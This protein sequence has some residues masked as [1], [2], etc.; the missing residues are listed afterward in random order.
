MLLGTTSCSYVKGAKTFAP[1]TFGMEKLLEHIFVENKMSSEI[2]LSLLQ[3]YEITR[4]ST[5]QTYGII[6]SNPDIIAFF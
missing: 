4:K 3:D 2:R 6:Q 1:E 5:E